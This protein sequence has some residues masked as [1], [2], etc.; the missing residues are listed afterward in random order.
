MKLDSGRI[1]Q[2]F[3]NLIVNAQQAM[4]NTENAKL[5]ISSRSGTGK[6]K[7]IVTI[8]VEDN[9]PGIQNELLDKL[10]EPYVTT[11]ASGSGLGLAIVKKIVEE[12]GGNIKAYNQNKGA[13]VEIILPIFQK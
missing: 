11:K 1:R 2:V 6:N 4:H 9:G 5:S 8:K 7:N 13:I 12:H 10:F 3:N